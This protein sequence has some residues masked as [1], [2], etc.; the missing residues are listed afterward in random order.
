MN[1]GSIQYFLKAAECSHFSKAAD[2]LFVSQSTLSKAIASLEKEMGVPLFERQGKGVTLTPYGKTF[3]TFAQRAMHELKTGQEAVQSL[4]QLNGGQLRLGAMHIMCTDFLPEL[5]WGF[6]D[7]NPDVTLS[8]QYSLTSEILRD[9][10]SRRIHLGVCGEFSDQDPKYAGFSRMLLRQDE[11]VLAV[12]PRHPLAGRASV[13]LEELRDEEFIAF[14][15]NNLG[16]DYALDRACRAAGFAPRIKVNAFNE[17]NILGKVAAGE[18]V[19]VV[20]SHSHV[21]PSHIRRIRF[22]GRE[23]HQNIYLVWIEED[24]AG[25]PAAVRFREYM[26]RQVENG[27]P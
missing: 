18:G 19:A 2:S 21:I 5:L 23:M 9:L 24:I 20:S 4:Y 3:Y 8:V 15:W 13:S 17:T 14:N 22:S 1:L 12:S 7:E 11:L 25:A 16:I 27:R 26:R 10:R 6:Q